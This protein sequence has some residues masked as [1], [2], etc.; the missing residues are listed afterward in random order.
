MDE[1]MG[2]KAIVDLIEEARFDMFIVDTA[3]TGHA[4]RLLKSP[5]I[6]DDWI[7]VMAKM[8]WKYRYV[9]ETFAGKYTPDNGDDFLVSLKKTVKRIENLLKDREQSEF[10]VV[11]IP[12]MMAICET[13][14][15]LVELDGFGVTVRRLIVNNVLESED[16]A[17]C[18]ARK[19]SQQQYMKEI[20]QRFGHLEIIS[21]PLQV[22]PVMG[23]DSLDKIKDVL[24]LPVRRQILQLDVGIGIMNFKV[25]EALSK[26]VGRNI[27]RFDPEDMTAMGIELGDIVEIEGKR[28]TSVKAMPCY[29]ED[30][31]KKIIQIDGLTRENAQISLDEKVTVQSVEFAYAVRITLRKQREMRK[32]K[33]KKETIKVAKRTQSKRGE[34]EKNEGRRGV[35]KGEK[36][37]TVTEGAVSEV[38]MEGKRKGRN[39][40][41]NLTR[42]DQELSL[43]HISEPTRPLYISYAVFCLKKKK[44]KKKSTLR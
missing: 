19:E 10:V 35:S 13:E 7:K 2:F 8:R 33:N 34:E 37:E 11:T 43:I 27:A 22:R 39:Q 26:D 42:Q 40:Q 6:I 1:L 41:R 25:K 23:L 44:K 5:Q 30:R 36:I 18:R 28:K 15:L 31:G 20:R 32:N 38:K 29:P 4:L 3:P 17:F 14:K 12:E 16:C 21:V 9:V 24:F